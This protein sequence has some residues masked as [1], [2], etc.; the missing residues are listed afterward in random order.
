MTVVIGY[1]AGPEG[2]AALEHAVAEARGS[3]ETLLVINASAGDVYGDRRFLQGDD[4]VVLQKTLQ[5]SGVEHELMQPARGNSAADEIVTTAVERNARLVVVGLRRRSPV[6]KLILGSTS[7]QVLLD[8]P[9]HVLAVK[10]GQ[11]VPAI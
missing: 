6:G 4:V 1:V 11:P 7:Q 9:C 8:A 3:S 2:D 5:D 10:S